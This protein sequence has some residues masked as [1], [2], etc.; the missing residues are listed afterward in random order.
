MKDGSSMREIAFALIPAKAL[1]RSHC[2]EI[3]KH[4][5]PAVRDRHMSKGIQLVIRV[6]KDT[7]TLTTQALQGDL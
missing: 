3:D 7:T 2:G 6:S 5:E 4:R 1:R